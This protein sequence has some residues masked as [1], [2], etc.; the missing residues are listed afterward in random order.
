M[1][2]EFNFSQLYHF[3]LSCHI[4]THFLYQ[5]LTCLVVF[6]LCFPPSFTFSFLFF[7]KH[8]LCSLGWPQTWYVA[9][10]D[11]HVFQNLIFYL[12]PYFLV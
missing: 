5:Q 6:F 8:I 10:G 3:F 11:I 7:L 12:F 9:E 1:E 2:L 4:S